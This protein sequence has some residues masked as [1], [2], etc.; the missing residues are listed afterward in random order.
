MI[1]KYVHHDVEGKGKAQD[2]AHKFTIYLKPSFPK[3][4]EDLECRKARLNIKDNES[5]IVE[6]SL[7]IT[8]ALTQNYELNIHQDKD[9]MMAF[10][11]SYGCKNVNFY[12]IYII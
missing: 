2:F 9:N 5:W 7:F 8:F 11:S 12:F 3:V 1:C 4:M 6:G 10:A